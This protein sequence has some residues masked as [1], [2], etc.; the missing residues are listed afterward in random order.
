M[1]AVHEPASSDFRDPKK[2]G[3]LALAIL[4][5]NTATG[6]ALGAFAPMM[7]A[8]QEKLG[9]DITGVS[10][11][12]SF[13]L[14][15]MGIS[16]PLVGYAIRRVGT[17]TVMIAGSLSLAAG[18]AALSV[19]SSLF[20]F[21]LVYAVLIGPGMAMLGFVPS[22]TLVNRYLHKES[23][24]ALGIVTA[25]IGMLALPFVTSWLVS[26]FDLAF[27]FQAFAVFCTFVALIVVFVSKTVPQA[28]ISLEVMATENRRKLTLPMHFIALSLALGF[29]IFPGTMAIAH[30]PGFAAEAGASQEQT[31]TLLALQGGSGIVGA[32]LFGWLSDRLGPA[33]AL[34]LNAIIQ[35]VGWYLLTLSFSFAGLLVLVLTV[36]ACSGG[37]MACFTALIG[38]I[39]S[40]RDFPEF[41]GLASIAVVPFTFGAA[42][43]VAMMFDHTG[44]YEFALI[45]CAIFAVISVPIWLPRRKT[46]TSS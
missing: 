4:A 39:Y 44:T 45:L 23:G 41:M 24:A 32:L 15:A 16:A 30:L 1:N 14:L 37:V 21:L 26:S 12:V 36:G 42:P 34:V 7:P 9:A 17:F 8:M 13:M 40:P 28:Q 22:T 46:G 27:A 19:L 3:I 33:S 29:L 43:I 31:I 35:G 25:P 18:F 10:F 2:L 20:I 38:K 11:A 5:Q 6:I